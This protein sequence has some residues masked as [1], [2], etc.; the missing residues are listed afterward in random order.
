MSSVFNF[1]E[2]SNFQESYAR[3]RLSESPLSLLEVPLTSATNPTYPTALLPDAA[4]ILPPQLLKYVQSTL[5]ELFFYFK[6]NHPEVTLYDLC[7]S[8]S[9][10]TGFIKVLGASYL[11]DLITIDSQDSQGDRACR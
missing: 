8:L 10:E 11:R 4:Q 1:Q 5:G 6:L 7:A 3:Q 9:E 2:V